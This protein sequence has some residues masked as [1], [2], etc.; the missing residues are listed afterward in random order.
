[1]SEPEE[2]S[3]EIADEGF[4]HMGST[5]LLESGEDP[6][7]GGGEPL[8]WRWVGFGLLVMGVLHAA[9]V[10]GLLPLFPVSSVALRVGLG[11]APYLVGGFLLGFL[12]RRRSLLQPFYAAAPLAF[13]FSFVME[14]GRVAATTTGDMGRVMA[15][16][17]WPYAL[18]P[19]LLY[20]LLALAGA[21]AGE[22]LRR[23][24]R[25]RRAG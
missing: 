6:L 19:V 15:Q 25:E 14:V 24:R 20:V 9:I 3:V 18:A 22:W 16:V 1:M 21:R 10:I 8:L 17:K 7:W 4:A 13:L 11:V 23:A 5:K 2:Q 12:P